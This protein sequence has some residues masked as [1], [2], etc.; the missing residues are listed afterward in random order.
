[1]SA[2]SLT[3]LVAATAMVASLSM[4]TPAA[5]L[6]QKERNVVGGVV[7][8]VLG[9]LAVQEAKRPKEKRYYVCN[10]PYRTYRNGQLV[11]VCR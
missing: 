9:T 5:A 3:A 8:G 7:L 4:P 11:T 2:K 1:M 10:S 6:N